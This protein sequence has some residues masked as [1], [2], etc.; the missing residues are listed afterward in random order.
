MPPS[1]SLEEVRC[2][3]RFVAALE[4][5]A[6]TES[7]ISHVAV[8]NP[9]AATAARNIIASLKAIIEESSSLAQAG[10]ALAWLQERLSL[11][12]SYV[13]NY[14]PFFPSDDLIS[15]CHQS[16]NRLHM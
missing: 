1:F 2:V 8:N 11:T 15:R 14:L 3:K 12:R 10:P 5:V 16:F 13:D 9:V 4:N 6:V 7:L